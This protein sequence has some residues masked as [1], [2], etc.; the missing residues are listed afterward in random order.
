[1]KADVWKM[2][3]QVNRRSIVDEGMNLKKAVV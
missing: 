1:M 2:W 3:V